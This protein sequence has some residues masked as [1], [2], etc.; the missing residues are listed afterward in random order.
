M[1]KKR[2][3]IQKHYLK[4]TKPR[5]KKLDIYVRKYGRVVSCQP[6]LFGDIVVYIASNKPVQLLL[7]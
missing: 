5:S 4:N 7:F 6:C 1:K 3:Y 2:L